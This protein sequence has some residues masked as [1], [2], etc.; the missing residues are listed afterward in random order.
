MQTPTPSEQYPKPEPFEKK[1]VEPVTKYPEESKQVNDSDEK[2]YHY[3]CK[4]C[5]FTFSADQHE[6]VCQKCNSH[7]IEK[8]KT[9]SDGKW[10]LSGLF[11]S[12]VGSKKSDKKEGEPSQISKDLKN[13]VN[14]TKNTSLSIYQ[15]TMEQLGT[16]KDIV[17][18][19]REEVIDGHKAKKKITLQDLYTPLIRKFGLMDKNNENNPATDKAINNLVEREM[20]KD[21]QVENHET[22]IVEFPACAV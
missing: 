14:N 3:K 6:S 5:E 15:K 17:I 9:K 19:E 16:M 21:D 20:T 7:S 10:S 2:K 1:Y 12:F 4:A 18:T 22:K 11:E 8:D 13:L